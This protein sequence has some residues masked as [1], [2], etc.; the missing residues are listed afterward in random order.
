[1]ETKELLELA[2]GLIANAYEGDWDKAPEST[3]WKKAAERWR[4]EYHKPSANAPC[5]NFSHQEQ[6][7]IISGATTPADVIAEREKDGGKE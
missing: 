3:G 2:W 1:M 6:Q 5:E 7:D 4:D